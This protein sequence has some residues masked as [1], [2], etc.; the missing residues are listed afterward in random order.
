MKLWLFNS[1][2]ILMRCL[3]M[4]ISLRCVSLNRAPH[5]VVGNHWDAWDLC[6]NFGTQ[7]KKIIR[8]EGG[9]WGLAGARKML[10]RQQV[11]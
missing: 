3:Q 11:Q 2:G 4:N 6:T 1:P 10:P 9:G 8:E 5:R 7:T